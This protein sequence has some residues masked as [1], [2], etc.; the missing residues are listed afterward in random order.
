VV[1]FKSRQV[2]KLSRHTRQRK[3]EKEKKFFFV[4]HSIIYIQHQHSMYVVGPF[5][6][7]NIAPMQNPS[8]L[9]SYYS[10]S[11]YQPF[12]QFDDHNQWGSTDT[13]VGVP[14][15]HPGSLQYH[16]QMY[17]PSPHD[18]PRSPFDYP[19]PHAY[20]HYHPAFPPSTYAGPPSTGT[21]AFD[22]SWN[23]HNLS[24]QQ[25]M[26][27]VAQQQM[28][29]I[30]AGPISNKK[31]SAYDG[32]PSAGVGDMLA[33]HMN[34]V[35][36][37]NTDTN[38]Y[39]NGTHDNIQNVNVL[40][41]RQQQQQQQQQ[42]HYQSNS[43]HLSLSRPSQTPASS[44]PKSYA[45]VVSADTINPAS[46]KSTPS[47]SNLTVRS[48][49]YNNS[50]SNFSNDTYNSRSNTQQQQS[51]NG[52]TGYNSRNQSNTEGFL[53]WRNNNSSSNSRDNQNSS[54]YSDRSSNKRQNY[55]LS[56]TINNSMNGSNSASAMEGNNQEV[57]ETR[58]RNH[59]YNPKDFNLNPKGARF[60]VIKSVSNQINLFK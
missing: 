58:K 42:Q 60:F 8:D 50:L 54:N 55:P 37:G 43:S 21:S 20:P 36:L 19:P 39:D 46:N 34:S 15:Q 9:Y 49:E 2:I 7:M 28:T 48:A 56:R 40:S 44:G 59:Q 47:I 13:S 12:G 4:L 51:R 53:N 31:P 17:T 52:T 26:Q 35:D 6:M 23:S 5:D 3:E 25:Q 27:V 45:S 33:Q 14:P 57:F 10:P 41:P 18:I 11:L 22:M 29:P 30:G 16:P 24:M 32:Y 1:Y 38:N